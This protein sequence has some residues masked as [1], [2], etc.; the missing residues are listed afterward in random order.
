MNK[1][2]LFIT[3]LISSPA[4]SDFYIEPHVERGFFGKGESRDNTGNFKFKQDG[5]F[6]SYGLRIGQSLKIVTWGVSG[7]RTIGRFKDDENRNLYIYNKSWGWG[8][9]IGFNIPM[10]PVRVYGSY[11]FDWHSKIT[12]N[13]AGAITRNSN[14][15]VFTFGLGFTM[16]PF[17]D[18]TAEYYQ[19][20]RASNDGFKI[21]LFG[22][23]IPLKF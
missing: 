6:S 7:L 11:L 22:V 13:P 1:I 9:F 10:L 16:F 20:K 4:F 18:F 21:Y 14:E 17:L 2:L 12:R 5:K 15:D 23:S 8:P 3:F 19:V